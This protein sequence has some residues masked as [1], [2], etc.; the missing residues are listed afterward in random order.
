MLFENNE[1]VISDGVKRF[2]VPEKYSLT[3]MTMESEY[4]TDV[5]KGWHL[6]L[7][8]KPESSTSDKKADSKYREI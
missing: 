8:Q 4:S 7:W 2:E 5:S 3:H 1:K 6:D